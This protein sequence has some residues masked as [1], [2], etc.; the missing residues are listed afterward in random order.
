MFND[1]GVGYFVY[2]DRSEDSLI[3]A[4]APTF[5]VHIDTPLRQADPNAD[6]FGATDSL[7]VNNV[8]DLTFGSTFEILN[9]ATLGTGVVVPVTG[10]KPFDVEAIAQLNYRF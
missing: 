1:L 8:V 7:R 4:V 3:T 6:Q 10:P 2:R 9:R 5:E